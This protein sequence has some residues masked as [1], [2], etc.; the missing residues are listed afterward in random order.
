M[1]VNSLDTHQTRLASAPGELTQG[2]THQTRLTSAE[3]ELTQGTHQTRLA[4]PLGELTQGLTRQGSLLPWVNSL[5]VLT[6]Q[7]SL[8]H[9]LYLLQAQLHLQLQLLNVIRRNSCHSGQARCVTRGW[10]VR[11]LFLCRKASPFIKMYDNETEQCSFSHE[12]FKI[13][14]IH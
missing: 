13:K 7:G 4:S 11:S 1:S 10:A 3:S 6:R 12:W 2:T 9:R 8:L 14:C 5:K